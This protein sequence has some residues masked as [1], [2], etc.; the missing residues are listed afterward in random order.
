[1]VGAHYNE[2]LV[3]SLDPALASAQKVPSARLEYLF[4]TA[5]TVAIVVSVKVM[6]ALMVEAMLVVPAAAGRNVSRSLAGLFAASV[7][8]AS[9]AGVGGLALSTR[10]NVPSGAAIVLALAALFVVSLFGRLRR[11]GRADLRG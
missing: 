3:G 6:G 1:M 5:L 2:L 4:V 7:V 11:R 8:A 10:V 9:L